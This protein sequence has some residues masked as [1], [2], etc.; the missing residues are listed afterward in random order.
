MSDGAKDPNRVR[1]E[2]HPYF[3]HV[4]ASALPEGMQNAEDVAGV[5][6]W[7]ASDEPRFITGHQL[8]ISAGNQL[9]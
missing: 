9:M 1:P 5:V 3:E 4:V 2:E 7:L 8:P 6:S